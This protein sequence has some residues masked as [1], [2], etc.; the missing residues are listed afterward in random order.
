[1]HLGE[2][3]MHLETKLQIIPNHINS[4]Q[5]FQIS[6]LQVSNTIILVGK[7]CCISLWWFCLSR[8]QT[9]VFTKLSHRFEI[10]L[11]YCYPISSICC[12]LNP[13]PSYKNS[14]EIIP[15]QIFPN[16]QTLP[17]VPKT[18]LIPKLHSTYIFTL[19]LSYTLPI[20]FLHLI[21]TLLSIKHPYTTTFFKTKGEQWK[22][23]LNDS[24]KAKQRQREDVRG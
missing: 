11:I 22:E 15:S 21:S 10:S 20:S 12:S 19:Y 7:G 3:A 18:L 16:Y 6:S 23:T 8:S 5:N 24:S 17:T 13:I 2:C 4:P 14:L 1:M 9:I